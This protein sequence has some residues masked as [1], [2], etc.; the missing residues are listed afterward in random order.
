MPGKNKNYAKVKEIYLQKKKK[1]K[2]VR[3]LCDIQEG[4]Y[5]EITKPASWSWQAIRRSLVFFHKYLS[6]QIKAS[7]WYLGRRYVM[8]LRERRFWLVK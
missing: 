7:F 4:L 8:E 5:K 2:N 6:K 1:K 3:T